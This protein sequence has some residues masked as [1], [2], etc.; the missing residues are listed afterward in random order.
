MPLEHVLGWAEFYGLRIAVDPGVVVPRRTE[1][2]VRRAAALVRL[3]RIE[4]HAVDIEPRRGE[5]RPP[6]RHRR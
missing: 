2:L 3:G 1:L 4:L 5:L 6:Q